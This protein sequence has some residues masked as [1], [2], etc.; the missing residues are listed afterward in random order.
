VALAAR[1]QQKRV[2]VIGY[3][4]L[5]SPGQHAPFTAA[6]RQGLAETGFVEG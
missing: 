3:L 2:P 5:E 1:A 4:G 6:F